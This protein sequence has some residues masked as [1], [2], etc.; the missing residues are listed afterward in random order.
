M[1][2]KRSLGQNFLTDPS[3]AER[4]AASVAAVEG[5]ALVEIGPGRGALTDLLLRSAGRIA[6]VE[7]DRDLAA[8]LRARYDE[9]R[10][11]LIEQ[12]IL[13]V[14]LRDVLSALGAPTGAR[15]VVVGNLPYNISKPVTQKLIR[16]REQVDRAVLM[17]QREVARRLTSSPGA[18]TY[19]PLGILA[20]M[21]FHIDAICDVQ[22]AS[23]FPR[24]RVVSTVTRWR[25]NSEHEWTNDEERHLRSVLSVCFARRRRTLRNNLRAALGNDAAADSL[26]ESTGLDGNARAETLAPA[27]FVRLARAWNATSLL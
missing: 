27:D 20:R 24:P 8:Q 21:M 22:P 4:I 14:S 26:L 6:A 9:S 3:V 5:E 1:P 15:L 10:L 12:D 19:G 2:P 23:F 18:R 7:L 17:F 25:T 16:E 13:T 11:L